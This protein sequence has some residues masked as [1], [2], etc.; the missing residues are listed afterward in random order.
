[1]PRKPQ[2]TPAQMQQV[3]EQARAYGYDAQVTNNGRHV[4][5]IK[6]PAWLEEM[7]ANIAARA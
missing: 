7:R 3:A 1:M 6:A 4:I 2:M 5:A